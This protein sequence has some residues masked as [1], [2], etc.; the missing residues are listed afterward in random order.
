[1]FP[2]LI[3]FIEPVAHAW[4]NTLDNLFAERFHKN[5]GFLVA[6]ANVGQLVVFAPLLWFF[7]PTLSLP[8]GALWPLLLA[9]AVEYLYL[10]PYYRA[11][12]H[13]DTSVVAALFSLSKVFFPLLAWLSLGEVLDPFQYVGFFLIVLSSFFLTVNPNHF[14]LNR[15]V[16]LMLLSSLLLAASALAMRHAFTT[17]SVHWATFAFWALM[18]EG[19][20][21]I[22]YLL[23]TPRQSWTLWQSAGRRMQGL[24]LLENMCGATGNLANIAAVSMLPVTV[25]KAIGATQPIFVLMYALLFRRLLPNHF[26][27]ETSGHHPTAKILI[28]FLMLLG[29]L[30]TVAE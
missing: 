24:I 22:A 6:V 4:S 15:A 25:V 26:K 29:I 9:V 7:S 23:L 8:S 1:M 16:G 18:L 19:A 11:L 27:E 2:F 17:T 28:F 12:R 30:L 13:T 3:A 14:R 10:I 21:G 20:V 5:L